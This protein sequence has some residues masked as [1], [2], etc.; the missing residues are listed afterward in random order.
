MLNMHERAHPRKTGRLFVEKRGQ[1]SSTKQRLTSKPTER[2]CTNR[3][4][5][6]AGTNGRLEP[7]LCKWRVD[8]GNDGLRTPCQLTAQSCASHP[9]QMEAN[10]QCLLD[11]GWVVVHV[12][13]PWWASSGLSM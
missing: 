3:V 11:P 2:G 1:H 4:A 7:R 12:S 9:W 5:L 13:V 6:A 8:G 10:T